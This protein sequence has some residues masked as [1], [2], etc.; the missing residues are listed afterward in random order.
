MTKAFYFDTSI[1]LDFF[2]KRGENGEKA[3][4][5][6]IKIIEED[7]IIAYSDLTIKEFKQLNYSQNQINEIFSIAKPKNIKRIHIYKE[8]NNEATKL[9]RMKNVPKRDALHAVLSRDNFLQLISRDK[10]F[11]KLKD[12]A[13]TKIPE[14]FI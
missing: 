5:L 10:H 11:E 12:I 4:K 8:Q 9:S 13:I 3:L 1:W 6:I 7:L 14:D 2:E